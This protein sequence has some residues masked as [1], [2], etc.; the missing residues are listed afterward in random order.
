MIRP[1]AS[2][3]AAALVL[4]V[5]AALVGTACTVNDEWRATGFAVDDHESAEFYDVPSDLGPG[6]PGELIRSERLL[7]APIGAVAWRVLYHSTDAHGDDVVV[8]GVVVAPDG[9][10]PDSNRP[11]V[12]W[13]HPTTGVAPR[14]APSRGF[15]PFVLIEGLK[16]FI[17][18]GYTVVA[19]DYPGMGVDGPSS[20]LIGGTAGHA[21]LDAVR[22]AQHIP[23][24]GAGDRLLLWGHSQGGQAAL[25]AAQDVAEYA[26]EL[27]LL[28]VAV[29]A[30]A[31]ELTA[32]LDADI[33][34]LSGV[35]IGSYALSAYAEFYGPD[36]PGAEL[37][38][39]LTDD[40]QSVVPEMIELCLLG[41]TKKLHEL[42]EPL[43][44]NFVTADL[45]T[46]AP[47]DELLDENTPGGAPIDAPV[48]VGQG[49]ADKL[50]VPSTTDEYVA[51]LCASGEHVDYRKFDRIGHGLAAIR[52]RPAVSAWFASLLAGAP[53]PDTCD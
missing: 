9:S 23:T 32:L 28:G 35:T 1:R 19:T 52:S 15:D 46:T 10:G 11:V 8:S 6:S 50:V 36:T 34:Q 40:A 51:R 48:F 16:S 43:V 12:S 29:A 41:Q 3:R 37:S 30:P 22:A 31:A 38:T 2:R 14:C 25:F 49:R 45:A 53:V 44:G 17:D 33:D 27:D 42:A 4:V 47:W 20:Y 21:V 7:G 18:D 5:A 26:P 39:V 24:A 13:G